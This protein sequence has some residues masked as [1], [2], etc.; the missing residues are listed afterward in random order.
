MDALL[1]IGIRPLKLACTHGL[2]T[3]YEYIHHKIYGLWVAKTMR[4]SQATWH[5][6]WTEIKFITAP[7]WRET[8]KIKAV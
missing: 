2:Q 5:A 3:R 6:V 4:L 8:L 7:S 1:S